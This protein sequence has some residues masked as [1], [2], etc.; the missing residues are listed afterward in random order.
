ME[1]GRVARRLQMA[2]KFDLDDFARSVVQ[3]CID[4]SQNKYGPDERL[5]QAEI[6]GCL[7]QHFGVE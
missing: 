2:S 6:E 3:G 4:T 7:K 5:P 1:K